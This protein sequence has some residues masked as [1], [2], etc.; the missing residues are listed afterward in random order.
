[1]CLQ[2]LFVLPLAAWKWRRHLAYGAWSYGQRF[3][4]IGLLLA[5]VGGLGAIRSG[6]NL[7]LEEER[8]ATALAR[9]MNRIASIG[10]ND[11]SLSVRLGMWQA[12]M[13]MIA[14]NPVAGVG[15][16]SWQ[17]ALPLHQPG[18]LEFEADTNAHNEYVQMVAEYGLAGW[19]FLALLIVYSARAAWLTVRGDAAAADA[20][21]N[22]EA[23]VR[24]AALCSLLGGAV[25]LLT[26]F[27]L[28]VSP[29]SA[30]LGVNL[31][32]LAAS[33]ARLG[34]AW[35]RRGG[36]LPWNRLASTIGA[37]AAAAALVAVAWLGWRQVTGERETIKALKLANAVNATGNPMHPLL[38]AAR[39]EAL[40]GGAVG[41]ALDPHERRFIGMLAEEITKWGEYQ[42]AAKIFEAMVAARPNVPGLLTHLGILHSRMNQPDQAAVYLE[43]AR[44]IAPDA[45]SVRNL[46]V[47][48]RAQRGEAARALELA[49]SALDSQIVSRELLDTTLPLARQAGDHALAARVLELKLQ[50]W[51]GADAAE[52]YLQLGMLYEQQLGQPERALEAYRQALLRSP[53]AARPALAA[54]I[55]P[56]QAARLGFGPPAAR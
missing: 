8:G 25:V 28:H 37:A 17:V 29:T 46:D 7:I 56:A 10:P 53:P 34:L 54:R 32:L 24:V 22:A 44:R 5:L 36:S 27:A 52:T 40:R 55:P 12:G 33:D 39:D 6:N 2:L 35:P 42:A 3:L 20:D 30:L 31:G 14:A 13:R 23:P 48:L 21:V 49:R 11:Y 18:N 15:A 47:M 51:P 38:K 41:L 4:A 43:R 19:L 26:G 16:G 1:M 50:R 9:G 45:P